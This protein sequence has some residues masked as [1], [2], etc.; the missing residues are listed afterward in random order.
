MVLIWQLIIVFVRGVSI[1]YQLFLAKNVK[2]LDVK[3][4]LLMNDAQSVGTTKAEKASYTNRFLG[5]LSYE[6]IPKK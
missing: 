5:I 2:G 6:V 3:S 1:R 4:V